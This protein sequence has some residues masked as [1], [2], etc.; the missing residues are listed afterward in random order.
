MTTPRPVLVA[1]DLGEQSDEAIRQA[2][3]WAQRVGAPLVACHVMPDLLRVHP[4]LPHLAADEASAI[5]KLHERVGAALV[6]RV[7]QLTRRDESDFETVLLEG[8]VAT[9]LLQAIEDRHPQ[10]VVLGATGREPLERALLGTSA[11][12]IIRH[13]HVPVLVARKLPAGSGGVLA[14]DDFSDLAAL[15]V[16]AASEEADRRKVP[17]SLLHALDVAHPGLAAF[18]ASA[19]LPTAAVAALRS[20]AQATLDA[21]RSR[22]RATG[23]AIVVESSPAAGIVHA[24]REMHAELAVVGT[25]G[26]TGLRRLA[27]GSVAAAVAQRAPCSVLV[28][29][30]A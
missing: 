9:T 28:H 6:E 7:A 10:L 11:D 3:A 30:G 1:T 5:P 29:R 12:Q 22:V 24:A 14:A 26:R 16:T 20:A 19:V 8:P 18:D 27:L 2:D 15:A 25:H 17:L 13:A 4:L 21:Q 23:A